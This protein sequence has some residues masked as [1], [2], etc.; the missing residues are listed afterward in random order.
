MPIVL[1]E[2]AVQLLVLN[3]LIHHGYEESARALHRSLLPLLAASSSLFSEER[4]ASNFSVVRVRKHFAAMVT[5]GNADQAIA[6]A[7]RLY[8][9][10]LAANPALSFQ[11]HCQLFVELVRRMHMSS[12]ASPTLED[13]LVVG[14]QIQQM[15]SASSVPL[16]DLYALVAYKDPFSSPLA[17]LLGAARQEELAEA[18]ETAVLRREGKPRR[19]ALEICHQQTQVCTEALQQL[20]NCRPALMDFR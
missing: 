8:P 18:L 9:G 17:H 3:F 13:L 12:T 4:L 1:P 2:P 5:D 7:E 11:L 14:Q 16:Q 10:L 6:A 20:G 19:S 15:P